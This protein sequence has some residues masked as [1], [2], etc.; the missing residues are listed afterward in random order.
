[1]DGFDSDSRIVVNIG[2]SA[3]CDIDLYE[4]LFVN[5]DYDFTFIDTSGT[6]LSWRYVSTL[7]K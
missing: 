4:L 1:V 5:F 7:F 3:N 6:V 2:V